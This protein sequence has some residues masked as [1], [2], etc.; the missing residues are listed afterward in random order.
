M[1][2]SVGKR[3]RERQ[4]LE[5]AQAKTRRKAARQLSEAEVPED[6]A[7]RSETMLV[8][9]LEALHRALE[10]GE[11]SLEDFETRRGRIQIE[12]ERLLR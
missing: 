1:S 6:F 3:Q 7:P 12:L 5:R 4:K 9:D 11:V 8:G 2:S 10:S